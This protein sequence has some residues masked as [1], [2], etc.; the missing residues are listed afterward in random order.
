[1]VTTATFLPLP[2]YYHSF[3]LPLSWDYRRNLPIYRGNAFPITLSLST[4]NSDIV[5]WLPENA[6]SLCEVM[7]LQI[8][9]FSIQ[10]FQGILLILD[11]FATYGAI[12]M[13]FD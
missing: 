3:Y 8:P 4:L 7:S 2:Q 9:K 13:C 10:N 5:A 11:P 6:F 1:V 12:S